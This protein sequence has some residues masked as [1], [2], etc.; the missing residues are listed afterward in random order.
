MKLK[1][2]G[3]G[4]NVDLDDGVYSQYQGQIKCF[5]CGAILDV[6]IEEG[7]LKSLNIVQNKHEGADHDEPIIRTRTY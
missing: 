2:L 3:C 1:C 6:K 7:F 5:A 4:H